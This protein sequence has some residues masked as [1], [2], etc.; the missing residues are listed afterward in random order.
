M[1]TIYAV[2]GKTGDDMGDREW[3]VRAFRDETAAHASVL[4]L[5]KLSR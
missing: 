3:P 5:T 1:T 2:M 4:A